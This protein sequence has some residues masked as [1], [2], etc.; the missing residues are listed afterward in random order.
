MRLFFVCLINLIGFVAPAQIN[1]SSAHDTLFN[2]TNAKGQKQ[3]YWKTLYSN[4]HIK[5]QGYFKNDKPVGEFKKYFEDNTPKAILNYEQD[6]ITVR[7]KLFYENGELA[8]QGKYLGTKKDSTWNYYSYYDKTLTNQETYRN[9]AK[10]GISY[11][12]YPSG[13]ICEEMNWLSGSREG[14]RKQYYEDGKIKCLTTFK[15]NNKNGLYRVYYDNDQI[16]L[17]GSYLND[18]MTGKWL[19]YDETGK[20]MSTVE[21]IN[22]KASNEKELNKKEQEYFKMVEQNKGKFAEPDINDFVPDK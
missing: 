10:Q 9:G 12:Y 13:R 3:G 21:Y 11:K 16:E 1:N 22:G 4:G 7:A 18:V 20:L 6:G 14:E 19:K 2:Q 17:E 15:N 8:A 5:Y